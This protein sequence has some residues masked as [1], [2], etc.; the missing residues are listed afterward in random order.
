MTGFKDNYQTLNLLNDFETG[1]NDKVNMYKMHFIPSYAI[2]FTNST[3]EMHEFDIFM[4][5]DHPLHSQNSELQI[6]YNKFR[7]YVSLVFDQHTLT[8]YGDEHYIQ[9]FE[10]CKMSFYNDS[11]MKISN[12]FY[13]T[14][15]NRM[16]LNISKAA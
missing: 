5:K 3:K 16:C 10:N 14:L 11:S 8:D 4:N 15:P 9:E 7:N 1:E 13:K 6:D 2:H 12:D